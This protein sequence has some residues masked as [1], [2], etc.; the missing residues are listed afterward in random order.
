MPKEQSPGKPTIRFFEKSSAFDVSIHCTSIPRLS[1]SRAT[2]S[3]AIRITLELLIHNGGTTRCQWLDA[4]ATIAHLSGE[5][6]TQPFEAK[7]H[8]ANPA[9]HEPEQSK[10]L[11]ETTRLIDSAPGRLS[12]IYQEYCRLLASTSKKNPPKFDGFGMSTRSR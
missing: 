6:R 1:V 10:S 5:R 2:A 9:T 7:L 4:D 3:D 11:R 12:K 8:A